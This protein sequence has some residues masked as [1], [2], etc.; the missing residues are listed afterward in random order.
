MEMT[1]AILLTIF[2][3]SAAS[4]ARP[5]GG[6]TAVLVPLEEPM[7]NA[8]VAEQQPAATTL[9]KRQEQTEAQT[10]QLGP[11]RTETLTS[12]CAKAYDILNNDAGYTS[13]VNAVFQ[14]ARKV[15]EEAGQEC[16]AAMQPSLSPLGGKC[17]ANTEPY[18]TPDRLAD[19]NALSQASDAALPATEVNKMFWFDEDVVTQPFSW[20]PYIGVNL[21]LYR[22]LP[23]Y[24]PTSCANDGDLAEVLAYFGNGCMKESKEAHVKLKSRRVWAWRVR[25]RRVRV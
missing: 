13:T 24:V 3:L 20:A 1:R 17:K 8:G 6:D 25:A 18:W 7:V 10:L 23:V 19:V 9:Q 16:A 22:I 5:L 21:K 2:C 12:P 14:D 4:A 15:G 11:M